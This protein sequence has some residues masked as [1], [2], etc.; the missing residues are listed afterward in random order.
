LYNGGDI[1]LYK[2]DIIPARTNEKQTIY[3]WFNRED[4]ID[5]NPRYQR[6]SGIWR[7]NI[8]RLFIDSIIN[9]FDVPKFYI[10]YLIRP[11]GNY[12]YAI[13][14]GKQRFNCLFSFMKNGFTLDNDIVFYKDP[15]IDLRNLKFT[16]IVEKYPKIAYNFEN[17]I[18]DV[19][20]VVTD[21]EDKIEELFIRLNNG[22]V[23]NNAEK[24][25]AISGYVTERVNEIINNHVF[26]RDIIKFKNN[27]Y[28][29]QDL[30]NKII[31]LEKSE[32]I[33]SLNKINLDTMVKQNR[34][35]NRE[36]TDVIDRVIAILDIISCVFNE[37][38]DLFNKKGVVPIYYLFIKLY[39]CNSNLDIIRDFL[40]EFESLRQ[41]NRKIDSEK[42]VPVLVLF[43]RYN[44]Q[45]ATSASSLKQRLEILKRYFD[46]HRSGK[47]LDLNTT[48]REDDIDLAD[49]G[50]Y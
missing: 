11:Q 28:D 42:Q 15:T 6:I 49:L 30:L 50:D 46:D 19:V 48:I 3:D 32:E 31:L 21:E 17:Y 23:L 45:G 18:L 39:R 20:Q 26:F 4:Q 9:G 36:I 22:S 12:L 7:L 33:I 2:F 1:V 13:I 43:D 24:R 47:K 10:H 35:S 27:R 41:V 5:M 14:D 34:E 8:K 29:Y 44:Q 37:S 40:L 38:P 16:D 25:N